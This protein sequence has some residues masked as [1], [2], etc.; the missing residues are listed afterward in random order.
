MIP[1]RR[2]PRARSSDAPSAP[3]RVVVTIGSVVVHGVPAGVKTVAGI[4]ASMEHA[5][6]RALQDLATGAPRGSATDHGASP[7]VQLAWPATPQAMVTEI[8]RGIAAVARDQAGV[9]RPE[10]RP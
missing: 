10:V 6:G 3:A 1:G 7:P 4:H 5:L 2:V 9:P 8:A